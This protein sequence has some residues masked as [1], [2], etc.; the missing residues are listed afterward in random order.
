MRAG[1]KVNKDR[2]DVRFEDFASFKS[3]A[4]SCCGTKMGEVV[5]TRLQAKFLDGDELWK[6][7]SKNEEDVSYGFV[8][9][10]EGRVVA[11]K[12]CDKGGI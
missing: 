3:E 12:Y 2:L 10:R 8:I 5:S 7:K 9:V 11:V 6:F 1:S 4:I